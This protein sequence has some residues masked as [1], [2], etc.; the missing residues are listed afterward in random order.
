MAKV[1]PSIS[2]IRTFVIV[3]AVLILLT[4]NY[5]FNTPSPGITYNF[6]YQGKLGQFSINHGIHIFLPT[7]DNR[8]WYF[9]DFITGFYDTPLNLTERGLINYRTPRSVDQM[10]NQPPIQSTKET[11]TEKSTKQPPMEGTHFISGDLLYQRKS[12][13]HGSGPTSVLDTWE[14]ASWAGSSPLVILI[15]PPAPDKDKDGIMSTLGFLKYKGGLHDIVESQ[16]FPESINTCCYLAT[17]EVFDDPNFL[18][19]DYY[20]KAVKSGEYCQKI[21][22][23]FSVDD[24]KKYTRSSVGKW[25]CPNNY[26]EIYQFGP[27]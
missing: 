4:I 23:V 25:S 1:K 20:N 8:T 18:N 10:A 11:N 3:I 13:Q 12:Q 16:I 19:P 2:K 17:I 15:V 27:E 14:S 6:P 24:S 22:G 7:L 26:Q 5:V 21:I 9:H